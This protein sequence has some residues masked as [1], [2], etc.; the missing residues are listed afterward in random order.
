MG[1]TY[2]TI[3]K[4]CIGKAIQKAMIVR[5]HGLRAT[6][7]LKIRI[8]TILLNRYIVMPYELSCDLVADR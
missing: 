8:E 1:I 6:I 3:G 7:N 2:D 5:F 4:K